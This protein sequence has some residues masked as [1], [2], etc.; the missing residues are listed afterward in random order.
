M[1][2]FYEPLN[3]S[4]GSFIPETY[5]PTIDSGTSGAEITDLNPGKAYDVDIRRLDA[6][7]RSSA[8]RADT[9]NTKQQDRAA[10]FMAAAKSAGKFK[11]TAQINEATS[12]GPGETFSPIGSVGYAKKPQPNFGR[13]FV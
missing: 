1:G 3:D 11:Q 10:K 13:S 7:A 4:R 12:A 6:S 5:D 8:N 9:S 2:R